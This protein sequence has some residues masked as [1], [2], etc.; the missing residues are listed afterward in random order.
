M[1]AGSANAKPAIMN[2][3]TLLIKLRGAVE[4]NVTSAETVSH[5]YLFVPILYKQP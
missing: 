2:L 5:F 3:D 4:K 1:I